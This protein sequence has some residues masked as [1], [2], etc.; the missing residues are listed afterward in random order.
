MKHF[1][2]FSVLLWIVY[3]N[4]SNVAFS[5]PISKF[6][7]FSATWAE[8]KFEQPLGGVCLLELSTMD[9]NNKIAMTG[10]VSSARNYAS[11]G[12]PAFSSGGFIFYKDDN[13]VSQQI[14]GSVHFSRGKGGPRFPSEDLFQYMTDKDY[15]NLS[16]SINEDKESYDSLI[17]TILELG[18]RSWQMA[19]MGG[20]KSKGKVLD[21][22]YRMILKT[23]EGDAEVPLYLD[24]EKVLEFV[25]CSYPLI[26]K[27]KGPESKPDRTRDYSLVCDEK[28]L[29]RVLQIELPVSSI[30]IYEKENLAVV[31]QQ[32]LSKV[33][34]LIRFDPKWHDPL[35][36][37]ELFQIF[38]PVGADQSLYSMMDQTYGQY[39]A[40]AR[41]NT[42]AFFPGAPPFDRDKI[43]LW[44]DL[45]YNSEIVERGCR[46]VD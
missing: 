20:K 1:L 45:D 12:A 7:F 10:V 30:D 23:S 11:V 39:D 8:N 40:Y 13:G 14:K 16:G 18:S 4:S 46:L 22:K 36:N 2:K 24:P 26:R 28:K 33:Y 17:T 21:S 19:V 38:S 42:I 5:S 43:E 3:F 44:R 37:E 34:D 6:N 31:K 25:N 27:F 9:S 15:K 35:L 32:G 29:D 41:F